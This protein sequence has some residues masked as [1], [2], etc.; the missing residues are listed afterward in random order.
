MNDGEK[1]RKKRKKKMKRE[2]K[3]RIST[4]SISKVTGA[5]IAKSGKKQLKP[6]FFLKDNFTRLHIVRAQSF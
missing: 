3:N 5:N 4:I 1:L 6:H 2:I